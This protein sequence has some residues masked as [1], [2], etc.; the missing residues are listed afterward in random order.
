MKSFV[1][2]FILDSLFVWLFYLEVSPYWFELARP[3][4]FMS[5]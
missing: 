4:V 5:D 1:L 2:K 3:P